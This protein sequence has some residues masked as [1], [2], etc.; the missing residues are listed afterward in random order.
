MR[1]FFFFILREMKLV[2]VDQ[3]Q[4]N[5]LRKPAQ[6]VHF[7][8]TDQIRQIINELKSFIKTLESPHGKPAGLAATQVG[9]PYRI[10]LMQ[11]PKEAKTIRKDVY[12]VVPLTVCINPVYEP[13]EEEGKCKDWEGCYS[14]PGKMGEVFRWKAVRY[15][16]YSPEG[17]KISGV[18]RGLLAR[19]IQH[20]TG[21]L[22][23]ELFVDLRD[24]DCRFGALEAM[25]KIRKKEFH[26]DNGR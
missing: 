13:I 10:F 5:V 26:D 15:E 2:T 6:T 11:I 23:G 22:N 12:D 1:G 21:H 14:V 9:I 3:L 18:A 8:L 17:E 25:M 19:I 24:H 20:E 7:P 16:A 4:H